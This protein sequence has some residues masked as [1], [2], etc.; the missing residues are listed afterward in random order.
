MITD[1]H[2]V[3]MFWKPKSQFRDLFQLLLSTVYVRITIKTNSKTR[4]ISKLHHA[5]ILTRKIKVNFLDIILFR[6]MLNRGLGTQIL[7]E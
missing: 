5:T 6:N 4:N 1:G 3:M 7:T 2:A